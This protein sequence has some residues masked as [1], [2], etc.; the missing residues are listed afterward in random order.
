VPING[1]KM[2]EIKKPAAYVPKHVEIENFWNEIY[3]WLILV[4]EQ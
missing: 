3:Q 1:N 2:A 4:E